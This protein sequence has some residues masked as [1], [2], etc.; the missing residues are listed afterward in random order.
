[1]LRASGVPWTIVRATA[2]V[3]TWAT[4]MAGPLR[5][6]GTIPVFGRGRNPI[7]FVSATDVAA[8]TARAA[9]DPGLRGQVLELGGQDNMTFGPGPAR[10]AVPDLPETSARQALKELLNST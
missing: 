4:I 8:L 9:T 2:F 6:S 1:T 5:A 3:E 10:Q 7:N